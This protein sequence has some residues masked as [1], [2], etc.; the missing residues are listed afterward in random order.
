MK[1]IEKYLKTRE[2]KISLLEKHNKKLKFQIN[3]NK[4]KKEMFLKEI[5]NGASALQ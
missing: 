1:E 5:E 4:D 2:K 3:S